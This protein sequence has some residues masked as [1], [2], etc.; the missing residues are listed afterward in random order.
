MVNL[1]VT[2]VE[3]EMFGETVPLY[4]IL[5]VP[6]EAVPTAKCVMVAVPDTA[7]AKSMFA[8]GDTEFAVTVHPEDE[9]RTPWRE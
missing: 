2:P 6:E 3:T 1:G 9:R 8:A 5:P 4:K 7:A